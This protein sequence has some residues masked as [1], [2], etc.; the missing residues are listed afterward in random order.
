MVPDGVVLATKMQRWLSHVHYTTD[1]V[2]QSVEGDNIQDCILLMLYSDSDFTGNLRDSRSTSG[3]FMALVGVNT[4]APLGASGDTE[5]VSHSMA[6]AE[7]SALEYG[8]RS[9]GL[10]AQDFSD[11]D[12]PCYHTICSP[13]RC[14]LQTS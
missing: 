1:R 3:M 13:R 4:L 8:V 11:I 9:E 2:L 12:S 14:L 6:V 7:V 10:L 5:V